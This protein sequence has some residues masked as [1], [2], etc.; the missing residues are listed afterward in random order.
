MKL[1]R[2]RRAILAGGAALMLG[3]AAIGVVGAQE[4]PT[5]VLGEKPV[6][7]VETE[8]PGDFQEHRKKFLDALAGKLGIESARLEQAIDEVSKEQGMTFP[9]VGKASVAAVAINLG[10]EQRVIAET[11]NISTEQ[12]KQEWK[13]RTLA[14]VAQAHNVDPQAVKDA[15]AAHRHAK[16]DEAVQAGK[17][18]AEHAERMKERMD[19]AIDALLNHP[20]REKMVS[21]RA[22]TLQKVAE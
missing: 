22:A 20:I 7:V 19:E 15:I 16:I 11:L 3:G 18:P 9:M 8:Q 5:P 13:D 12:L 17:I 6:F 10:D 2:T 21:L 4:I 14:E 1:S